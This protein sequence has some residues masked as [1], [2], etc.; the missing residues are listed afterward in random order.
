MT[1]TNWYWINGSAY[2][3]ACVECDTPAIDAADATRGP[4]EGGNC[5]C[6]GE[7]FAAVGT[8][9]IE[10]HLGECRC[11]TANPCGAAAYYDA[12]EYRPWRISDDTVSERF[13]TV[14]EAI[15]GAKKWRETMAEESA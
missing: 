5:A 6:C 12:D 13:A 7:T 4:A 11:T 8:E 1:T 3:P 9:E 2:C 15:A 10:R 14:A